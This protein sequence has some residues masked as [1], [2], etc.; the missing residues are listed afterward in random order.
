MPKNL[1]DLRQIAE[2]A[3]QEYGFYT[4]FSAKVQREVETFREEVLKQNPDSPIR[5]LRDLLWSSIDNHDSKDLDQLEYCERTAN[6][7]I[8]VKVAIADVDHYVRKSTAVDHHAS[9]NGTSVY[10]GVC[11]FSMLPETFSHHLSSLLDDEDRLA[12]VIEYVI[13]K[14]G[15]LRAGEIFRAWVRN[16]A[17]LV[18]EP[19]G[20]WLDNE[21]L[22][23]PKIGEVE[24]LRDQLKLQNEA[25]QRLQ[26][27][28]LDAGALEL[29]TIEAS[30][31]VEDNKVKDIVVKHKNSAR[32]IIENF[33]I[34]ANQTMVHFLEKK[35]WP[36]I[37]RV[38]PTPERWDRIV[39]VA[40]AKGEIL[41]DEPN[42]KALSDFLARQ[43]KK[44]P[45]RFPDLSV[46][47]VKLLGPGEYV[48]T[49]K[50]KSKIGHFGL[51][52]YDYTHSTAPNRRY[53]DLVIQ[54][55]I[56]AALNNDNVPYTKTELGDIAT[57]CT[58]RDKDSKKVERFMRKVCGAILLKDRMG[59]VF[60]AIVT[61]ASHKGTYVRLIHP[62]VEGRV[63]RN[64]IGM[65][66]G[67]KVQVRLVHMEPEN[68]YID[69][70]GVT[71]RK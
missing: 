63:M 42:A 6:Q 32:L 14:D 37:Q 43:H 29:E 40:S 48:L 25:A 45:D 30:A 20:E 62:P 28:R 49:E 66:I 35:G 23:P 9:H 70:E 39:A 56:K 31:L 71:R 4:E 53:V 59:E 54:R 17:K 50:G 69:F 55:L 10:T 41:P 67:Q 19:V 47:I 12:I 57:S 11:V 61:G 38:V 18:Y 27:F 34:A 24:G 13:R 16:K 8:H 21:G 33:M 60:D 64:H 46:T 36:Y 1:F 26:D 22:M 51:A 15:T 2:K 3:A 68:G 5:D 44:D 58:Q 65:D 7:E 52:V